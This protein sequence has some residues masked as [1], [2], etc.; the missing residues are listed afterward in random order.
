[1][2]FQCAMVDVLSKGFAL[3]RVLPCKAKRQYLLALLFSA[4][5]EQQAKVGLMSGQSCRQFSQH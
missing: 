2:S 1:M 5:T 4:E 3:G